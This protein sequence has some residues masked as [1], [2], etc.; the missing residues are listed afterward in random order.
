[1]QKQVFATEYTD[2]YGRE[3]LKYAMTEFHQLKNASDTPDSGA[4]LLVAAPHGKAGWGALAKGDP[5][6]SPTFVAGTAEPLPADSPTAV[7]FAVRLLAP[8]TEVAGPLYAVDLGVRVGQ[9]GAPG[10]AL[11]TP[12]DYGESPLAGQ[13]LVVAPGGTEFE[14]TWPKV[15]RLHWP[16]NLTAAPTGT[17]SSPFNVAQINIDAGVYNFDYRIIPQGECRFEATS[18]NIRVNLVAHLNAVDGPVVG[19]CHGLGGVAKERLNFS[20]GPAAGSADTVG[21]VSAGSGA[22]LFIN[23]ERADGSAEYTAPINYMRFSG[24][25]VSA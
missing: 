5:G 24:L 11:I 19:I 22:V 7:T 15:G 21:K 1:M 6:F 3:W 4:Y 13:Q 8:A 17:T 18:S 23:T 16:A 2:A 25:V 20:P 10:A 9:D 12:E 14:L